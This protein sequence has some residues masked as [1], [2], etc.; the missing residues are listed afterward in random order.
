LNV[1]AIVNAA[2]CGLVGGGGVDGAIHRAAGRELHEEC[3]KIPIVKGARC[4][5]GEARITDAYKLPCKKI[6]HTAG[7]GYSGSKKDAMLLAACYRNSLELAARS[8]LESVAF[9]NISTG[10][11]GYPKDEAARIA[12]ETVKETLPELPEIQKV[13]FVSSDRE[14]YALY[15]KMGVEDT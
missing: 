7:P 13:I 1:D 5:T 4:P 11:Y 6:I 10:I 15:K 8:G 9:P 3:L 14:N 12:V 2:N